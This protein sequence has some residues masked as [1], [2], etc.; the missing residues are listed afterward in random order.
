MMK[1]KE[2]ELDTIRRKTCSDYSALA[3]REGHGRTYL[4]HEVSGNITSRHQQMIIRQ[5]KG[6]VGSA[7]RH[8]RL[9]VLDPSTP[10]Y[11][12]KRQDSPIM[13]AEKLEAVVVVPMI[14]DE[15]IRGILLVGSRTRCTYTPAI[16]TYL[17]QV[18]ERY[19]L[20]YARQMK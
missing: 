16:Q 8:G 20:R 15:E 10:E 14:S 11:E 18:A 2:L 13:L 1:N 5:G 4:W 19:A 7:I 9:V 12:L 17:Q 6:V 3:W